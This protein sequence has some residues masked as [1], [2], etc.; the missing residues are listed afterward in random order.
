MEQKSG[1]LK[2]VSTNLTE[3]AGK[4]LR[5]YKALHFKRSTGKRKR[6]LR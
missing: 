6:G 4:K 5:Q 3:A 1:K 2:V